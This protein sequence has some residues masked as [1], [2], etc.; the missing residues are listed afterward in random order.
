MLLDNTFITRAHCLDY[1]PLSDRRPPFVPSFLVQRHHRHDH[2]CRCNQ[3][4]LLLI[5][6]ESANAEGRY[7]DLAKLKASSTDLGAEPTFRDVF[8]TQAGRGAFFIAIAMGFL[9]QASGTEAILYYS[10]NMLEA[11]GVT[12]EKY[13]TQ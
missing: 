1:R 7:A 2:H 3:A 6:S 13:V 10:S 8:S 12:K 11:C 5:E 4:A 9:Q